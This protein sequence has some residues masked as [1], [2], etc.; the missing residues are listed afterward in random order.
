[1][2]S[3]KHFGGSVFVYGK[4]DDEDEIKEYDEMIGN[5]DIHD[6]MALISSKS[7]DK[8]FEPA[9][10][11]IRMK[12]FKKYYNEW[13]I[14]LY[15]TQILDYINTVTDMTPAYSN[16]LTRSTTE[17]KL[18]N[19][20]HK[21]NRI[22]SILYLI[23][24]IN[25]TARKSYICT[26]F[27]IKTLKA[28]VQTNYAYMYSSDHISSNFIEDMFFCVGPN[29][30]ST[31]GEYRKTF[32]NIRV[33]DH[34][35]ITYLKMMRE[36][37]DY[38]INKD[39]KLTVSFYSKKPI[40]SFVDKHIESK[41]YKMTFLIIAW[42]SQGYIKLL[43]LQ[44]DNIDANYSNNMF[45]AEDERFIKHLVEV[46]GNNTL[47]Q[48]YW[49]IGAIRGL[50]CDRSELMRFPILGQKIIP[51]SEE[52]S[53]YEW[54]TDYFEWREYYIARKASE[55]VSNM[56]CPGVPITHD[57][58]YIQGVDLLLFNNQ[59]MIDRVQMSDVEKKKDNGDLN[60]VLSSTGIVC[61]IEHVGSTVNNIAKFMESTEYRSTPPSL[62]S[63]KEAFDKYC[64]DVV[65]ALLCLNTKIGVIHGDLHLNN[66]TINRE[67]KDY[68]FE[69]PDKNATVYVFNDK[70]YAFKYSKHIGTV[71]D[72]SRSFVRD[73]ETDTAVL[74]QLQRTR[75]M[76]Y[77]Q[78]LFPEF[79]KQHEAKLKDALDNKFDIVYKVFTAI[80]MY[81]H[82][83]RLLKYI[84]KP[85]LNTCDEAISLVMKINKI[86]TYY[87]TTVMKTVISNNIKIDSI[88]Y[89][90]HDII[91]QC[92][93]DY[94]VMPK[95]LKTNLLIE[96]IYFY[97]N[98][99]K[100]SMIKE[101]NIHPLFTAKCK[102]ADSPD[103]V[104]I[105]ETQNT[106]VVS[107]YLRIKRRE[108]RY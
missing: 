103:I 86:A 105:P 102:K 30:T 58:I 107:N 72:F 19:T 13:I 7:A 17:S 1:M 2:N 76:Q 4:N 35:Q 96:R 60:I 43:N 93:S 54:N 28:K 62:F 45:S 31:D 42:I 99:L 37:E 3:I 59:G 24:R 67:F 87:L 65:Y 77:Y 61:L 51:L 50:A 32:N 52:A 18:W 23:H 53:K 16:W 74:G 25:P 39:I 71:I 12:Y 94:V 85:I 108:T 104:E 69:T 97:T 47:K 44:S 66:T 90:N 80:D 81:T 48:F 84:N 6:F 79:M 26:V 33:L 88:V 20:Y 40:M 100:Y 78:L 29:F 38:L 21:F 55:L 27:S 83:D 75:I 10:Y 57:M 70:I 46:Y 92:F 11:N 82:T 9:F 73:D 98:D 68:I 15:K 95:H 91:T 41:R 56:I 14:N 36:A 89:P 63:K 22:G 34:I 106:S 8:S 5:L 101:G 64:F 49:D